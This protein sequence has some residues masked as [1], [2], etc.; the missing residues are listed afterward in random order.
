M[1]LEN[2]NLTNV[3]ITGDYPNLDTLVFTNCNLTTFNPTGNF[4]LLD[5]LDLHGNNLNSI[6]LN[7][8]FSKV[9][10]ATFSGNKLTLS[11]YVAMESWANNLEISDGTMEFIGN[12]DS[13]SGTNLE[14][15]L[16]SKG[17]IVRV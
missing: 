16:I 2:T 12:I 14:A 3:Q 10:N 9:R 1:T 4:P 8:T 5:I 15:I 6:L 11:S 17:R 13:V 7:S